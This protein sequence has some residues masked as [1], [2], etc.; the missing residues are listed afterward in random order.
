[1]GGH[2][3]HHQHGGSKTADSGTDGQDC[4]LD[5]RRGREPEATCGLRGEA[6]FERGTGWTKWE[7]AARPPQEAGN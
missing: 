5:E 3:K 7:H 6:A 1:M 4:F 2:G